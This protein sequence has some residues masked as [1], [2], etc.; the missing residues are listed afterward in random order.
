MHVRVR[1]ARHLALRPTSP[2]S[3]VEI[4]R[5]QDHRAADMLP[6]PPRGLHPRL[7]PLP[8]QFALEFREGREHAEDQPP[9]RARRVD[10]GPFAGQHLQADA[11]RLQVIHNPHQL[12]HRAAQP[13]QLPDVQHV[14]RLAGGEGGDKAGTVRRHARIA[15]LHA[16]RRSRQPAARPVAGRGSD[17]PWR[18]GHSRFSWPELCAYPYARSSPIFSKAYR[19]GIQVRA[20][21]TRAP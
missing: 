19:G 15:G 6:A 17:L 3:Q 10:G 4:V 16:R 14:A 12:R 2:V 21:C 5:R 9:L 8:D 18:R 11:P 20:A 7:C 13:V 1:L